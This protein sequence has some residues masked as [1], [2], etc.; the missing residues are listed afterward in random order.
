[1]KFPWM[2]LLII[3]LIASFIIPIASLGYSHGEDMVST[4]K[5]N[6]VYISKETFEK[7]KKENP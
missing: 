1:M 6:R 3:A 2:T 4:L 5:T 7:F